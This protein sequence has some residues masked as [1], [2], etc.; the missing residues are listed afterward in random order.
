MVMRWKVLAAG[1]AASG[2]LGSKMVLL[3][4]REGIRKYRGGL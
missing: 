4:E 3:L 2:L 1:D